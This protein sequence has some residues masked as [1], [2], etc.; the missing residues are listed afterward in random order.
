MSGAHRRAEQPRDGWQPVHRATPLLRFWAAI[1]ALAAALVVNLNA[2]AAASI[3][4]AVA[5]GPW[6]ALPA[7]VGVIVVLC[8]LIW[9]VSGLWWKATGFRV[10]SEEVALKRGVI[11]NQ[12]RTAR[13][14]RIQAVDVVEPLVPRIF[15]MAAVRVESA[16]G[17]ASYI[18]ILYLKKEK[19]ESL[20]AELLGRIRGR[21]PVPGDA[22]TGGAGAGEAAR[23]GDPQ[24]AADRP[25]ATV[26]A[27]PAGGACGPGEMRE[28]V[29]EIP[30]W[31]SL[32]AAALSLGTIVAALLIVLLV[33]TPIASQT[34]LA[35][36][37]GIAPG[38][39]GVLNRSWRFTASVEEAANAGADHGGEP[40]AG[41]AGPGEDT[42]AMLHLSYGLADRRRQTI[43]LDRVHAVKITQTPLWRLAGWW[44]V[45]V[46]VAGYGETSSGNSGAQTNVLP[47][48]SRAEAVA[49][50]SA[51]TGL[52]PA[53]IETFAAPE[54]ARRATFTSPGVA[55]W[56]S[57]VDRGRQ[58]ITLEAGRV[59]DHRGRFGRSVAAISPE[60]IQ[61]VTLSH[62]PIQQAL[63][64]AT[65]ELNL[66]PGPVRMYGRDLR[67]AQ[68]E[69]L[70]SRLRKRRL[71]ALVS[72]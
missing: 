55:W 26:L 12:L 32:A 17:K 31:R 57:P 58:A 62:G 67:T 4:G 49:V 45:S 29:A 16:G 48:G 25:G 15:G 40:A 68:A 47:V 18:D 46:S 66:V 50:F 3:W 8:A 42:G 70:V 27:A 56:V 33:V 19:A 72:R 52:S 69:E 2:A 43:P 5:G 10:G 7:A 54:G 44:R 6:W 30:A 71:P 21:G 38:M 41:A 36:L 64:L 23:E 1:L 37:I 14:D 51:V 35:V 39:W 60:H 24:P 63:G 65:V 9:G 34:A 20:R 53:E 22:A 59:I 28:L 61:E 13:F 11:T